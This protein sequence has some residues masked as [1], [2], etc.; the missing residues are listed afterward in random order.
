MWVLWMLLSFEA[1]PAPKNCRKIKSGAHLISKPWMECSWECSLLNRGRQKKK[2]KT[3]QHLKEPQVEALLHLLRSVRGFS[4]LHSIPKCWFYSGQRDL[5]F[6]CHVWY[7]VPYYLTYRAC[8][9]AGAGKSKGEAHYLPW[10]EAGLTHRRCQI[11][12]QELLL[13][14]RDED[15][16]LIPACH[17]CS[18]ST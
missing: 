13:W 10:W 4:H 1:Q 7:P 16:G 14:D 12:G 3:N 9:K 11:V 17:L 8:E 2:K 5:D 6:L 15:L 18:M